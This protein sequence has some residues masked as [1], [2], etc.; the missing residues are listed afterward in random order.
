MEKVRT[1]RRCHGRSHIW[2]SANDFAEVKSVDLFVAYI[3]EGQGQILTDGNRRKRP[4]AR[5]S[6]VRMGLTIKEV[7]EKDD[8]AGLW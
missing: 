2:E 4:Q 5:F 3:G 8:Q 1:Q 7:T 6:E